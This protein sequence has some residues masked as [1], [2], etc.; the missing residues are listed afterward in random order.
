MSKADFDDVD[1]ELLAMAA[2]DDESDSGDGRSNS[3]DSTQVVNVPTSPVGETTM[4]NPKAE[5][6]PPSQRKGVAQKVKSRGRKKASGQELENG[7]LDLG[8]SSS[9]AASN[10]SSSVRVSG[11]ETPDSLAEDKGPSYP[12][13]GRFMSEA[14]REHIMSM[15]E[16]KREEIL[17]ERAAEILKKQQD[18]QLKKA[19]ATSQAGSKSKRKAETADLDDGAARKTSR[20]KVEQTNALDDYKK[21]R[22]AKGSENGPPARQAKGRKGKNSRSPSAPSDRDAPGENEIGGAAGPTT[23]RGEPESDLQ[24]L[25]QARIGRSRLARWCF[26]PKFEETMTGCFCRVSFGVN[27]ENGQ[28][29]YWV[30]QIKGGGNATR[31]R[32]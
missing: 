22:E 30:A 15:P 16:I 5:E 20:A 26:F 3:G 24:D 2:G 10:R 13:E 8:R 21:A 17:A 4:T 14:E 9:S 31:H 27:H 12:V 18:A 7:P 19:L 23:A 25:E 11:A 6:P 28:N 1:A 29:L 32:D